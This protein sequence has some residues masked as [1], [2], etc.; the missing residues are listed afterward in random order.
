MTVHLPLSAGR[1]PRECT[2]ALGKLADRLTAD[3]AAHRSKG[4]WSGAT[5]CGSSAR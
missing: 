5:P 3:A 1:G 4:S 2:R